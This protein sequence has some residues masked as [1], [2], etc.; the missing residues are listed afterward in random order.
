M[1]VI[2]DTILQETAKAVLVRLSLYD[3]EKLAD[4]NLAAFCKNIWCPKF[5]SS[6]DKS[7]KTLEIDEVFLLGIKNQEYCKS[8]NGNIVTIGMILEKI[9]I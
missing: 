2:Y 3:K 9:K 4:I 6:I 8:H 1:K 5:C 7:N